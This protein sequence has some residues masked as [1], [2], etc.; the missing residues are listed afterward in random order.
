MSNTPNQKQRRTERTKAFVA[1]LV[2]RYPRCFTHERKS[3]RPLAIGIQETLREDL[4]ADPQWSDTPNWLIKQA[5]ARYTHSPMYLDAVA[6]RRKRVA[7]DGSDAGEVTAEARDHA[8][9][10]REEQKKQA[11]QRRR[12]ERAQGRKQGQEEK[13]Q[14]KLERL[15]DKFNTS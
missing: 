1:E 11:T 3:I 12:Q 9:A 8:R 10:R 6:A 5:L 2:K 4:K 7:L 13:Q 14:R 15:A